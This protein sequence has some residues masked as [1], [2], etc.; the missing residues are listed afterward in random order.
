MPSLVRD[1]KNEQQNRAEDSALKKQRD[2]GKAEADVQAN[3]S[4]SGGKSHQKPNDTENVSK[5]KS[6]IREFGEYSKVLM[7]VLD[8][9]KDIHPCIGVAVLAFKTVISLELKRRD[10]DE[11]VIVLLLKVQDMMEVLVQLRFIS[12]DATAQNQS[13]TIQDRLTSICL[14][15]ENDIKACGNLCDTYSKKRLIVKLLKGPIYELRLAEFADTFELRQKELELALMMF[16]AQGVHSTNVSLPKMQDTMHNTNENIHML[17]LFQILHSDTEKKMLEFVKS[18]GGPAKCIEDEETLGE[19]LRI[20]EE[21]DSKEET[22]PTTQN[23]PLEAANGMPIWA[24]APYPT[25]HGWHTYNP[26]S[27]THQEAHTQSFQ[28]H[29]T[30]L[31]RRN[32]HRR[33]NVA[34]APGGVYHTPPALVDPESQ[35]GTPG[36]SSFPPASQWPYPVGYSPQGSPQYSVGLQPQ[37]ASNPQPSTW[38]PT[39]YSSY[40][41]PQYPVGLQ[42]RYASHMQS[43]IRQHTTTKQEYAHGSAWMPQYSETDGVVDLKVLKRE[44]ESDVDEDVKNNMSVFLRKFTEQQRQLVVQLELAIVRQGD[45]VVEAVRRGPHDRIHDRELR[46]IW[47]EMGWKL[48]VPTIEFVLTLHD[49][50]VS[51]H[52]DMHLL[53]HHFTHLSDLGSEEDS[54]QALTRVFAAAKRR[55]EEKWALRSLDITNL[56]PVSE[57]FDG[58]ASGYV[59]VWE[60]NQI[61]SLRP[62]EWSL[63]QWLAYWASGRHYAVWQYSSQKIWRLLQDMHILLKERVLPLNRHAIDRYLNGMK[64]LERVLVSTFECKDPPEGELAQRVAAYVQTEEDRMER[65]LLALEY[66]IDGPDTIELITSRYQIERNFFPLVYLLLRRHVSLVRLACDIVLNPR[67]MESAMLSMKTIFKAVK[68]RVKAL[69]AL[70][71]QRGFDPS[72]KFQLY[73]F[74]MYHT[75]YSQM[76]GFPYFPISDTQLSTPEADIAAPISWLRHRSGQ[77]RLEPQCDGCTD[78]QK[79]DMCIGYF[80]NGF[81]TGHFWDETDDDVHGLIQFRVSNWDEYNG[82]FDG[83]GCYSRGSLRVSGSFNRSTNSLEATFISKV[84]E[85]ISASEELHIF[86]SGSLDEVVFS[87]ISL[88]DQF[89][90]SGHWGVSKN[91]VSGRVD[92][93][94]TPAWVY[95][96]KTP[97]YGQRTASRSRRLWRFAL[98]AVRYQMRCERRVLDKQSLETLGRIR[99]STVLL[100]KQLLV[101]PLSEIDS[102]R[103]HDIT[104][105]APPMESRLSLWLARVAYWPPVH[106][107][108]TCRECNA[109]IVGFR[110]IYLQAGNVFYDRICSASA[111]SLSWDN[112][113]IDEV[114]IRTSRVIHRVDEQQLID[115]AVGLEEYVLSRPAIRA[116]DTSP[117]LFMPSPHTPR[118]SRYNW[119]SNIW[120]LLNEIKSKLGTRRFSKTANRT[121]DGVRFG[122]PGLAYQDSGPIISSPVSDDIRCGCCDKVLSGGDQEAIWICLQCSD[123][124]RG[125]VL[126]ICTRC[127]LMNR[128]CPRDDRNHSLDHHLLQTGL[129]PHKEQPLP[130][131]PWLLPPPSFIGRIKTALRIGRKDQKAPFPVPAGVPTPQVIIVPP[132]QQSFMSRM[133]TALRIGRKDQR[134]T[135]S[136]AYLTGPL[137]PPAVTQPTSGPPVIVTL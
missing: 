31:H 53:D 48:V 44:L 117:T 80:M 55:A 95:Q 46:Q 56:D 54:K 110:Y 29:A 128:S 45:R 3:G 93:V 89:T 103:L 34:Q 125:E 13:F 82:S 30:P 43:S 121:E 63:L 12:P 37:Y 65:V 10:N 84:D 131:P 14:K 99:E 92:F 5:V 28:H 124:T 129:R 49:Y 62:A 132:P 19:L 76:E 127:E 113:W 51:Q 112:I 22:K 136:P 71:F 130:P 66:E 72:W 39:G 23:V 4:A 75:V 1:A 33:T 111:K 26:P 69:E 11:K 74:G 9:I 7:D 90:I 52:H 73:A 118:S 42:P 8:Q 88:P 60:A 102:S 25:S 17:L 64:T 32:R 36:P 61:T 47:K 107:N 122:V 114:R 15:V 115:K 35:Y 119:R 77:S 104:R 38:Y 120:P 50:Y 94:Q 21:A 87:S 58:D 97:L 106:L 137:V 24:N 105:V 123:L 70:F 78:P 135:S 91:N 20:R 67:E 27:V 6:R 126:Y 100:K 40:G 2:F 16:T 101:G 81:W 59:S 57:V 41:V 68:A 133:K 79:F 85:G 116:L 96:I 98:D 108:F 134:R 83:E 18:K 109:A 86:V